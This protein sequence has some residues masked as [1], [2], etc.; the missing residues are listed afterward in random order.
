LATVSCNDMIFEQ[1]DAIVFDKDGTLADAEA[2]LRNLAHR[3][4]RLI[5]AQ[6]PGVQEPLLMAFG[7]E[8]D[9]LNPSGL[10]AVGSRL[11]N[12]IAAAA[13]IAET[14]RDWIQA[15]EMARSS[16][17]EAD[18]ALQRKAEQTP[19]LA[20]AMELLQAA[21]LA[22]LKLGILSSDTTAHIQDFVEKYNLESYFHCLLGTDGYTN[23]SEPR[24]IHQLFT[25]LG[26][27]PAQ[28]LMIGDAQLDIHIAQTAGMAGCIAVV[29]GWSKPIQLSGATAIATN[30]QE[31]R[32]TR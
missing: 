16:F 31:I 26:I 17:A 7:V 8:A 24:L 11:E 20:G 32:V 15:L 18:S 21:A 22:G 28:T 3:R 25:N 13:Y 23:K 6:I 29:G 19:P 14:G 9:Q 27:S 30:L 12:E 4:S 5:D 2:F 1:I 10:M